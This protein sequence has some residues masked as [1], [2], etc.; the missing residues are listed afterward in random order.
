LRPFGYDLFS[1]APTTF[2]PATEIPIPQN[3]IVGPGDTLK[4]F[5]YGNE[6]DSN[7][8][9]VDRDGVIN[10]NKIGPVVVAGMSFSEVKQ[11]IDDRFSTQLIG[12]KTSVTMGEL[13]SVRIFVLGEAKRSGSYT[14]SSLSTITNALSLVMLFLFLRLEIWFQLRVT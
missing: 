7:D 3:Y 12:V 8:Y 9:V 2:A 11:A 10:L 4:V 13:R 6:S 5:T 14:V 1:G